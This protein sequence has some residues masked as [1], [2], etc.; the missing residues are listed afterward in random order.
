VQVFEEEGMPLF[1]QSGHGNLYV[2]YNVVLPVELSSDMRRKLGEVFYGPGGRKRD[3][4]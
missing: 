4:L 1:Q 2:E 3:E